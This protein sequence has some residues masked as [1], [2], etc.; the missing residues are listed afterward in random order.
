MGLTLYLARHAEAH[1]PHGILYGRLPRVDLSSSG[2]Q[3]AQALAEALA[4]L[5][6]RAIYQSPLLRARRTASVVATR[7]PGVPLRSSR[8]LLENLHPYQGRKHSEIAELRDRVYDP[9]VLGEEG[10]TI[11]DL[12][13]RLVRFVRRLGRTYPSGEVIAV[14]H[15]DPLAALRAFLLGKELVVGSLRQEAPPLTGVFR[16]EVH[17][18]EISAPEW[19]YRPP[20]PPAPTNGETKGASAPQPA[21]ADPGAQPP[22]DS[23]PRTAPP[24][25]PPQRG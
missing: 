6:P 18:P 12:C 8:L 24:E 2:Q 4:V 15:A 19:F 21:E 25:T 11:D 13:E 1:N 17:G 9:E 3:Q 22:G 20:A 10:E 16:I 7:H 23:A 14:A 5:R